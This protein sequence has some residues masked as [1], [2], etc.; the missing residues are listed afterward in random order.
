MRHL[1]VRA[2][3]DAGLTQ[4]QLAKMVGLKQPAL[5][6]LENGHMGVDLEYFVVVARK[7][8]LKPSEV[9]EKAIKMA[10]AGVSVPKR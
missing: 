1:L 8:G 5:S 9:L 3:K 10:D 7:L 6:K 2:R 4:A